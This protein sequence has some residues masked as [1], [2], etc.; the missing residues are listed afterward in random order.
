M[1]ARAYVLL[2]AVEG[3]AYEVAQT[4]RNKSGVRTVDVLEGPP[5]L[6]MVIQAR[7]RQKPAELTNRALVSVEAVTENL[8]VLPVQ[9]GCNTVDQ[10]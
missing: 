4:L 1:S 9:N 10:A 8:Q 2:D 6:V 5:S 3:K 7:S